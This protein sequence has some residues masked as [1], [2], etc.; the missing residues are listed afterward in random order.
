MKQQLNVLVT[1]MVK[2]KRNKNE[3]FDRQIV[4]SKNMIHT[5]THT[6]ALAE[7]IQ[8]NKP[9]TLETFKYK[10]FDS[11]KHHPNE[12]TYA[13]QVID[14]FGLIRFCFRSFFYKSCRSDFHFLF[15]TK[16]TIDISIHIQL[17]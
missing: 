1:E 14:K 3:L 7:N 9:S 6:R 16:F 10:H 12:S 8:I 11:Q 2:Y 17:L 5:H 4:N 15:I 13:Q